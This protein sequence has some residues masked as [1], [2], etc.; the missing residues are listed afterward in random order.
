MAHTGGATIADG[1]RFDGTFKG[2]SLTV[3]GRFEGGLEL[4]GQLHLGPQARVKGKVKASA[5]EIEGE[6]E[7][8]LRTDALAFGATAR[9]TGVF[10][11][12]RLSVRDGARVDGA[13]NVEAAR[14]GGTQERSKAAKPRNEPQPPAADTADDSAS[15]AGSD[16]GEATTS[17]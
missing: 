10:V 5:V 4:S 17:A 15:A 12:P 2:G 16:A 13:V 8:E 14:N 1:A 6:F 7:G 11:A 3:L 9:A